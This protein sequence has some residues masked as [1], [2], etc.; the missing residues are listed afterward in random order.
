M[1]CAASGRGSAL[2]K[3]RSVT[4]NAA[5]HIGEKDRFVWRSIVA[6]IRV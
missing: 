3:A 1:R 4:A 2:E 6:T 5:I